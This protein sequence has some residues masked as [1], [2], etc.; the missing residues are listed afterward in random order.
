MVSE[1]RACTYYF[2]S[3]SLPAQ[4]H[5]T[6]SN[7]SWWMRWR[8]KFRFPEKRILSQPTRA[9]TRQHQP[10][11]CWPFTS[12]LIFSVETAVTT[13][14]RPQSVLHWRE[15]ETSRQVNVSGWITTLSC[16]D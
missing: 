14:S 12:C 13:P 7:P 5:R 6:G 3:Y 15:Q 8:G 1:W 9:T 2:H 11:R 10:V 4:R 16:P